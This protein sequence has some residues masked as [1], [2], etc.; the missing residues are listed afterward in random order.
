MP[1][2]TA[3]WLRT[4]GPDCSTNDAHRGAVDLTPRAFEPPA[5]SLGAEAQPL[6]LFPARSLARMFDR[7]F[8]VPYPCP[9]ILVVGYPPCPLRP[10][11]RDGEAIGREVRGD[12]LDPERDHPAGTPSGRARRSA[13][14]PR[15]PDDRRGVLPGP[16]METCSTP[17]GHRSVAQVTG[18]DRR[19]T[20]HRDGRY[21]RPFR[22]LQAEDTDRSRVPAGWPLL[23]GPSPCSLA[24]V[25]AACAGSSSG[26][27]AP[28]LL[29]AR[30]VPQRTRF[31]V[32]ALVHCM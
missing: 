10:F 22:A 25:A 19:R 5:L 8:R 17:A 3:W 27:A 16:L 30:L 26:H 11:I 18:C 9:P 24:G 2:F 4:R 14:W 28:Y 15:Q 31:P 29:Q 6:K 7:E 21:R 32:T 13:S 20:R 1:A 12:W 23:L